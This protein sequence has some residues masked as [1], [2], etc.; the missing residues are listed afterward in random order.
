M[1]AGSTYWVEEGMLDAKL[2]NVDTNSNGCIDYICFSVTDKFLHPNHPI[3]W[4]K[5][6]AIQL[7][8]A[9]VPQENIYFV[10]RDQWIP[11][12]YVP[13]IRDIWWHMLE[14]AQ[15]YIKSSGLLPGSTHD[16]KVEID[17]SLMV[18]TENLDRNDLF[19]CLHCSLTGE[20]IT[21]EETLL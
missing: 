18:H 20:L 12:V 10:I 15:I 3:G 7:D 11:V 16:I 5:R 19:K 13:T 17:I 4:I 6:I 14:K 21:Q 9:V 1:P 8:G 2:Y